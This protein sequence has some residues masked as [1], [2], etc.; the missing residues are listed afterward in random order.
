MKF[1]KEKTNDYFL[2]DTKVENM[3]INEYLAAADGDYV[4]VYLFALMYTELGVN[5]VNEDIA[6]QLA[7][8]IEDVYKAWSYWEKMGVIRKK[9]INPENSLEYD[10]EFVML[11]HMLYGNSRGEPGSEAEGKTNLGTHMANREY[12]DMFARIEKAVGRVISGTE[13]GEIISWVDDLGTDPEVIGFAFEYC[14]GKGKKTVRY[15]GTVI[16]NWIEDGYRTMD[17][18][19]THMDETTGR[20]GDYKRVFQALGFRR[21][22]SEEEKRLM[23]LWFDKMSFDMN[24]VLEACAKTAGI[25]NPSIS[26]VNRDLDNWY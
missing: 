6:K 21:L 9:R 8:N 23:D 24:K 25:S 2:F 10:V 18:V 12:K 3:F 14:A 19:K 16:R 20:G 26:Y 15:V 13:M 1:T 5:F 4:K 17:E 7:M 22:P 11:K